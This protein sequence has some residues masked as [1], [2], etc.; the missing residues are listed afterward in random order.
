MLDSRSAIDLFGSNTYLVQSRLKID[1]TPII[2]YTGYTPWW[3]SATVVQS[4]WHKFEQTWDVNK[5]ALQQKKKKK[6]PLIGLPS[7]GNSLDDSFLL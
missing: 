7:Q 6:T 1:V 3:E 5:T 2:A 4:L